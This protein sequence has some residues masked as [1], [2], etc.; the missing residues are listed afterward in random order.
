M[1]RMGKQWLI[2]RVWKLS[3]ND[4][5]SHP[6]NVVNLNNVALIAEI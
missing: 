2:E 4:P 3:G 6:C 1:R 5:G